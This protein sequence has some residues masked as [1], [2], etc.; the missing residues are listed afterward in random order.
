MIDMKRI[1]IILILVLSLSACKNRLDVST[2]QEPLVL[3]MNS[4]LRTDELRHRVYISLSEVR[5]KKL[6]SVDMTTVED[7]VVDCYL[8][9]NLIASVEYSKPT[10]KEASLPSE[11]EAPGY[12]FEAELHEGDE[13]RLEARKDDMHVSAT[14]IVPEACPLELLDTLSVNSSVYSSSLEQMMF[15]VRI[16]DITDMDNWMRLEMGYNYKMVGEGNATGYLISFSGLATSAFDF[17]EDPVLRGD[18]HSRKDA[19]KMDELTNMLSMVTNEYCVFTDRDFK[20]AEHVTELYVPYSRI[21]PIRQSPWEHTITRQVY[22][23]LVSMNKDEYEN[24][25]AFSKAWANRLFISSPASQLLFEPLVFP[26]NVEGGLG[27][28]C[29]SSVSCVRIDLPDV[30]FDSID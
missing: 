11:G 17:D 1:I 24:T 3:V 5:S 2:G 6:G 20:D 12:Y 4:S 25:V 13:I 26:S 27:L 8:N 14:T 16:K 7:A 21:N 30:C 10:T 18:F 15:R 22:F 23:N 28:V 29:A 19:G 9:G